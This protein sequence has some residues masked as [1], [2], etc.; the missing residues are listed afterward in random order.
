MAQIEMHVGFAPLSDIA[1]EIF[2][3]SRVMVSAKTAATRHPSSSIGVM[4]H[5]D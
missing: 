5:D 4:S 1:D 3:Q 2:Q